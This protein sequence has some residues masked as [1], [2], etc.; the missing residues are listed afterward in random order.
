MRAGSPCRLTLQLVWQKDRTPGKQWWLARPPHNHPRL[1]LS[2][3]CPSTFNHKQLFWRNGRW[4]LA[5]A[6][7]FPVQIN[8]TSWGFFLG[9]GVELCHSHSPLSPQSRWIA[10]VSCSPWLAGSVLAPVRAVTASC[11]SNSALFHG[12]DISSAARCGHA[13]HWSHCPHRPAA[14]MLCGLF[15]KLHPICFYLPPPF[16]NHSCSAEPCSS[17]A[18]PPGSPVSGPEVPKGAAGHIWNKAEYVRLCP[19]SY[20]LRRE[21]FGETDAWLESCP[22]WRLADLATQ[23]P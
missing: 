22:S 4:S 2:D 15:S 21:R 17:S 3:P 20:S 11:C 7:C 10:S 12:L 18:L 13:F 1:P 14:E 5:G 23:S 8:N 9:A 16:H 19:L 6:Q